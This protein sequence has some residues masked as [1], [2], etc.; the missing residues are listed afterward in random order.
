MYSD[1]M[2]QHPPAAIEVTAAVVNFGQ[3]RALD[4][5]SIAVPAGS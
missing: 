4:G 1:A 3:F 5:V 2:T